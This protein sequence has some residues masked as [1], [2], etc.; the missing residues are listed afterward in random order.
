MK[1]V[2]AGGSGHLGTI[3]A[4]ALQG[5]GREVVVLTRR[6]CARALPWKS[7]IWD[8][9]TLGAWTGELEGA[10]AVV[11]LAGRS[12]NCRY[13]A[14]NRREILESRVRSTRILGQ[15]LARS[16]RPP[17]AWLQSSTATIY[18]HRFD[19]PNDEADGLL[20]GGEPDAPET[21]R[22]SIDVA[23]R[24]ESELDRAAVPRT[25]KVKLR[26]AIVMSPEAGGTFDLLFRLARLGLGGRAGDGRQYVSW[27]HED[28]FVRALCRLIERDD[29]AGAVNVAAPHPL[30]NVQ[31]QRSLRDAA[32]R[33]LGIPAARWMLEAAAFVL[34]TE[35]EL[36]L[37][38]RRVVPGRLL[39]SGFEFRFPRWPEAA[40][41]LG[42][43]WRD[44]RRSRAASPAS[45]K[46]AA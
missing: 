10:A 40:A 44:I 39:E 30:P 7:V 6:T 32:G 2:L 20:G 31:F 11:N 12:V 23:T 29:L 22:F 18:A 36:L 37:K 46:E 17:A 33:T 4:A 5:E 24:W 19:A 21:W 41:D 9:K 13:G 14:R 28:D 34:R 26:T 16:R 35:T 45:P 43:R 25:R 15:A 42:R 3:L 8:G 27:I 38:S 1:I